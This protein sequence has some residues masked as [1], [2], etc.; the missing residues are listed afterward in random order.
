MR[1]EHTAIWVKDLERMKAF[2]E[3]YF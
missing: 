2:Y 1:I 3:T